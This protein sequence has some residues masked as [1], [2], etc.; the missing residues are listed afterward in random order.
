MI[1]VNS[2]S[3]LV[4]VR[5]VGAFDN[6]IYLN[7]QDRKA[8]SEVWVVKNGSKTLYD[9]AFKGLNIKLSH[10][11]DSVK[12][13]GK[14]SFTVVTDKGE[15]PGFTHVIITVGNHMKDIYK[16]STYLPQHSNLSAY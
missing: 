10:K 8:Q 6:F 7:P 2:Q 16:P 9:A 13:V 11:V 5:I 14:K 4:T 12:K 1:N 3:S 15:F